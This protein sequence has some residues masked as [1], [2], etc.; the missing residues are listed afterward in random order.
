VPGELI[1]NK[2]TKVNHKR[3]R[4][5]HGSITAR[6]SLQNIELGPFTEST[7]SN[8]EIGI[9][10]G[11][12]IQ[13]FKPKL[14]T[15]LGGGGDYSPRRINLKPITTERDFFEDEIVEGIQLKI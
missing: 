13:M 4:T 8:K 2:S 12:R 3:I 7:K 6:E 5:L 9:F 11:P 14:P 10:N 1:I 15:K